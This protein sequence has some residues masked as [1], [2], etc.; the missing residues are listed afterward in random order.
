MGNLVR[1][2][3]TSGLDSLSGEVH[4]LYL[5][6]ECPR[7]CPPA[8]LPQDDHHAA[9]AAAIAQPAPVVP[10]L[11]QV[12][13]PDMASEHGPI[14]FDLAVKTGLPVSSAMASPRLCMSTNAVLCCTFRSRE[15]CTAERPFEAF[16]NRQIAPSRST[17]ASLR[18][19]KMVPE[20]TLNWR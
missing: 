13:R 2:N 1:G 15:N 19:A 6:Q 16:T 9:L 7:Q 14:D 8:A 5:P 20:V 18:E 3:D 10:L 12:G 4:A 11:A 17:N